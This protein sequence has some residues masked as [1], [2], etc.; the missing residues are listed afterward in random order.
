M[1]KQLEWIPFVENARV[2][3]TTVFGGLYFPAAQVCVLIATLPSE[4]V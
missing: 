1:R 2:P 4:D 3:L